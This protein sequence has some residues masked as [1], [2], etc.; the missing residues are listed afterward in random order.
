MVV[1]NALHKQIFKDQNSSKSPVIRVV[2]A[3]VVSGLVHEAMMSIINRRIIL[4]QFS[5]FLYPKC[6]FLFANP[7]LARKNDT[8]S[9][10]FFRIDITV[11]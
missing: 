9:Y 6:I 11:H 4:G 7:F 8:T 10:S 3:F 1:R 2:F 5:F